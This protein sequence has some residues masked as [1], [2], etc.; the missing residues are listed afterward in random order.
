MIE[1][2]ALPYEHS[3]RLTGSNLF[4][5]APGAVLEVVGVEVDEA[6]LAAWRTRADRA[7]MHLGWGLAPAAPLAARRHRAGV[8]LALAAPID[9]LFVATE[10]NEWALAAAVHER[11]PAR[12]VH[13]ERAMQQ[14]A[15]ENVPPPAL[16]PVLADAAALER[17][18][19]LA[20]LEARPSLCA[21]IEA[22]E[23]HG[24]GWVL[25]DD[26][27]SL[28]EGAGHA[29]FAFGALPPA[30]ELP[31]GRLRNVP[32][33]LVTGSNGKTTTVR[34]LAACTQAQGWHTAWNCTDG[35]FV[36]GRMQVGGDLSGPFGARTVLR[37]AHAEAA[38]IE[39]ARGGILRR[40]LA[41]TRADVAIVTNVSPDHLGDSGIDDLEALA[42][43]KLVVAR[44]VGPRGLVVL[45]ADDPI[46]VRRAPLPG[47][48][49]GLFAL[50]ADAPALRAHRDRGG[51]TCGA[52]AGRL[53]ATRGG[54]RH[55]LG[56]IAAMPL[57]SG[58]HAHYN[59][60]N[61]AAAA[62]GALALGVAPAAIARVCAH[63]GAQPADN[64]GRLMRFEV[65]GVEAIVDFAHN[66]AGLRGVLAVARA[67]VDT[68][69]ARARLILLLG[70][71]GDR[72]DADIIALAEAAADL[73]PDVVIVKELHDYLR[74]RLPGEVPALL[75]ATLRAR[76]YGARQLLASD[77]EV[78][79]A[80]AALALAQAGD[81][82][83]LPM[84]GRAARD[85]VTGLLGRMQAAGWRAGEVVPA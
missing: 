78:E 12:W 31:W 69:A 25:D 43:V 85:E 38:I 74:G 44:L 80:R 40:G 79:A 54:T 10:L 83:L 41:P 32:V 21:A 27:L 39:A 52:R 63:F 2:L 73:R 33:A 37:E 22:A 67:A 18:G 71:A 66:P 70:Q 23:A 5:D 29:R 47:V 3:R 24:L 34:L 62:L 61:L 57:T 14:A 19:R 81:V 82:L 65:G 20:A 16:P 17:L 30:D 51:A 50:D 77:S 49:L 56:E 1:P 35:V 55:D 45:N 60:A 8:S 7:R 9:Q 46:L 4:F 28:G 76:G 64:P 15:E 48:P 26:V 58:G 53:V 42:D 36:D 72:A 59:I 75:T 68:R 11:D 13:I 84:H 6:L